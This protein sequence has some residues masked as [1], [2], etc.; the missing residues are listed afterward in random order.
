[1]GLKKQQQN[2]SSSNL[3]H[4]VIVNEQMGSKKRG[5]T[6]QEHRA[7]LP[8]LLV[9]WICLVCIASWGIYTNMD[10][11]YK[12]RRKEVLVSMC[13]QR[14][15]MLQDQFSVSVNHVHALAVMVS[16]FHYYK[17]PSAID[18]V[19]LFQFHSFKP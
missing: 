14:A 3:F 7:W 9:L 6:I 15:R 16:T 10:E 13:D 2:Q 8:K 12:E 11:Q 1:M 5:Y 4:S 19:L 17:N 18:Q